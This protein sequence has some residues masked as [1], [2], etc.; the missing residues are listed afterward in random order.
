M[1]FYLQK[2]SYGMPMTYAIESLRCIFSKGWGVDEFDVYAGIFTS[3]I[4]IFGLL[5]FAS[6]DLA[7]GI[8]IKLKKWSLMSEIMVPERSMFISVFVKI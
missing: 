2:I 7:H 1:P 3:I 6:L 8:A 4:W 5:I